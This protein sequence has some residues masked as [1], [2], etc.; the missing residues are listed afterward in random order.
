MNHKSALLIIDA[1]VNMFA[2]GFPVY[3]GE[4]I[5]NTLKSLITRARSA[6]MQVIYVQNNGGEFDPDIHGTPGWEIHPALKPE[7][8]DCIIQKY[9]PDSFNETNLQS[10]LDQFQIGA[11]I[12]AGMQTD[13]CVN[14]TCRR[15][16]ALGYDVTLVNDGHSTVDSG[17]LTAAQIIAQHN[18][19]L[20]TIV[21]A[22][23][24]KNVTFI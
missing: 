17:G 4:K 21:K 14:A 20:G 6:Q 22:E 24:A 10:I 19:A 13:M 1:Q 7:P 12:I 11:L 3:D 5:L 9:T 23:E 15:A 2:E 8:G 18:D 16:H